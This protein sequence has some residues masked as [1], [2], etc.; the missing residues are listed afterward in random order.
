MVSEVH[1]FSQKTRKMMIFW[2]HIP[3]LW[4]LW[5]LREP[6]QKSKNGFRIGGFARIYLWDPW[7][8]SSLVRIFK[9]A[10]SHEADLYLKVRK[11]IHR[12]KRDS[13]KI[14]NMKTRG[15]TASKSIETMVRVCKHKSSATHMCEQKW[16]YEAGLHRI[17]STHIGLWTLHEPS[18]T[19]HEPFVRIPW[20][21]VHL[22]WTFCEP[23]MDLRAPSMN[24]LWALHE[25]SCTFHEPF[26]SPPWT[27][28][29]SNLFDLSVSPQSIAKV[30]S[31]PWS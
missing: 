29:H 8:L 12:S 21:F 5:T 15:W 31:N 3:F 17:R 22:P 13:N 2:V 28:S 10:K 1:F 7:T 23:S 30:K 24:L 11:V 19:F 4:T 25:P 20:T 27:F 26:V 6:C 18:L 14:S 9:N 16:I